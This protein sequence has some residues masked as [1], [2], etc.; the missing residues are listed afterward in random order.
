VLV[1]KLF[2][3]NVIKLARCDQSVWL[4]HFTNNIPAESVM[5]HRKVFYD[6][7]QT[8]FKFVDK[9]ETGDN[10]WYYIGVV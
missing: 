7:C 10:D 4:S 9:S 2:I 6:N 8:E 5:I 3:I 1:V